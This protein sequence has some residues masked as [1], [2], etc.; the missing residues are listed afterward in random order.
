MRAQKQHAGYSHLHVPG[1]QKRSDKGRSRAA[2]GS[3]T[4]ARGGCLFTPRHV[5]QNRDHMSLVFSALR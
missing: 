3:R 2:L 4:V 1:P 5:A